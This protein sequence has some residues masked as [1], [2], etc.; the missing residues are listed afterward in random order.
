[1]S[2]MKMRLC[3]ECRHHKPHEKNASWDKC[4]APAAFVI[5]LVRG[6][7]KSTY[8]DITRSVTGK[9]GP[10][11]ELFDYDPGVSPATEEDFDVV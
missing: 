3:I 6:Q 8:A 10:N 11:A 2:L 7:H 9:C 4:G 5:D 1:M